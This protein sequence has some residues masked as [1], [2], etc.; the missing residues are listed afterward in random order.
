MVSK[1]MKEFFATKYALLMLGHALMAL[2]G[3]LVHALRAHRNGSSKTLLDFV[4]L[5]VMS[6]FSGVIFALMAIHFFPEE[7]YISIAL[8]GTGGYLGIEGM[9][10][11]I[12]R[13]KNTAFFKDK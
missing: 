11:V 2:F 1:T 5:V 4:A 8:A 3:A 6:S 10:M 9:G 7:I 13:I 12:E